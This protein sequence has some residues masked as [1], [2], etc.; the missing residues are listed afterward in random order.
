MKNTTDFANHL[1]HFF[2]DFLIG[3][4][5]LSKNTISSYSDTFR[6]LVIFFNDQ[7]SISPEKLRLKNINNKSVRDY[8]DWLQ[9][10]RK[11]SNATRN[12]RLAAIHSFFRYLQMQDPKQLLSCQQVM[13]IPFKKNVQRLLNHLTV[14]QVSSLLRQPDMS[15]K[16]ERRDAVILSV[17]YDT[18]A[19]VQELCDLKVQNIRLES[20]ASI[21]L[22]GKGHKTRIVPIVGNTV[23]LL[24]NYLEEN[25]LTATHRLDHPL[26]YNQ[27]R[28]AL[29]RG[30]ITHILKK[31]ADLVED[32]NMPVKVTPHVLRHSKAMHLLQAG[33]T[34]VVIRDWLGH[35]SIQTTEIYATLDIEAKR[36]LLER[37]FPDNI[38]DYDLPDWNKDG[39]LI[40]FLKKF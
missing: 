5:N 38:P 30:G 12:Q 29:S 27:R 34:M 28:Q 3:C 10:E 18:G 23:K 21:S 16:G 33:Y 9:K 8:L 14:S 19:R 25:K 24:A 17:L 39:N 4:R 35:V 6:L 20:P 36:K 15:K 32:N 31:Y 1:E 2:T 40:D 26:F 22:T 11:S 13:Q 37:T 7:L